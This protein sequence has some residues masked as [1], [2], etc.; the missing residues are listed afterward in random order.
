MG[1]VVVTPDNMRML[2]EMRAGAETFMGQ[3]PSRDG[4][5]I[6]D[7]AQL[8]TMSRYKATMRQIKQIKSDEPVTLLNL[9]CFPLKING[10]VYFPEEIEACPVGKPYTKYVISETRWGHK[11]LGCDMQ[12]MMQMEP[13]PA[14]PL[15]LAS[16]YIREYVQRDGGFGGVLCYAGDV[17]PATIKKGE[18]VR[19]PEV[20]YDERGEL[21]IIEV[22]RDFHRTLGMV[23]QR[24]NTTL[25]Q[26]L[27]SANSWYENDHQRNFVNDTHRDMARLAHSE[28]I[29][30][31]LPRWVMIE[32]TLMDKQPDA[33]PSCVVVPKAG[34]IL[35]TNCG[36]I[37]EV[38][39]AF[40][41]TRIAYGAVEMERLTAD[42]W[43][44]VNAIQAER[45]KAKGIKPA[46]PKAAE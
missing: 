26:R 2:N 41:N 29:I 10:G 5:K 1:T 23:R 13:V 32:N 38:V 30:P 12:N 43:K 37:F 28:G 11:D 33:C 24:R 14:I 21:Y 3:N 35:C 25:I 6:N 17:D 31:Y 9:N 44:V 36:H 22:E 16:E 7:K 45:Q 39:K 18:M 27:Q 8:W 42:E 4:R 19:V 40:M 46:A 20:A 34:A 15:V